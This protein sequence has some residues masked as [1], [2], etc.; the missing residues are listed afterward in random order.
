MAPRGVIAN[1]RRARARLLPGALLVLV[2]AGT[3]GYA[4]L[5]AGRPAA[6]AATPIQHVVF[7]VQENR[8]FDSYFGTFPGAD[9]ISMDSS[10]HPTV[11]VPDPQAGTCAYPFHDSADLNGGGP[12]DN[13]DAVRDIDAGKMDGFVAVKES[14]NTPRNDVMGYHDQRE[15]PV[16]WSYAKQFSLQDHMFGP[17]RAWSQSEH[18][19]LVSGWSAVCSNPSRAASCSTDVQHGDPENASGAPDYA[20]TDITYLLH[21]AGISWKYYVANGTQPDCDDGQVECCP[22]V[23]TA[24]TFE[25]WNP[26]RD[27]ATVHD[28]GELGNI[29][30]VSRFYSAAASGKLPAVSWIVPD[31]R[32]SEHPGSSLSTGQDY[33]SGLINTLMRSP[34]WSSTAVF[35]TWD[36]WGGFYDHVVPPSV[37]SVGYGIRVPGLLLSPWARRGYVDHQVLSFDAYLKFIEHN[38]LGGQRIDPGND[39]RPDPRPDVREGAPI[40]GDLMKEFDFNS[41]PAPVVTGVGS[42]SAKAGDVVTVHGSGLSAATQVLF[43]SRPAAIQTAGSDS[44]LSVRVPNGSG[45]VDVTVTTQAGSSTPVPLD[46]F[47]YAP[48]PVVRRVDP[49]TATP[50]TQ[51]SITG[52]GFS[53]TS[54]VSFG[55]AGATFSV[56]S[57]TTISALVPDPPRN[58]SL[59]DVTVTTPAGVSPTSGRDRFTYPIQGVTGLS[60]SSGP[61]DACTA[62]TVRGYGFTGATAVRFGGVQA[63]TTIPISDTAIEAVSPPGAG[64][65]DVTVVTPRGA[66]PATPQDQYTYTPQRPHVVVVKPTGG[67]TAGG[68]AVQINGSGF[69]G[70]TAVY[71]GSAPAAQFQVT[72]NGSIAAV[73]PPGSG[74]VDVTVTGPRGTSLKSGKF[75]YGATVPSLLSIAPTSGSGTGGTK[76]T[77]AGSGFSNAQRVLFGGSEAQ[78]VKIISDS[79]IQ[80]VAPPGSGTADVQVTN[81]VG[82]SPQVSSDTFTWGGPP[83]VSSVTPSS[84]ASGGGTVVTLTGS[85]FSRASEVLIGGVDATFT[86]LSDKHIS[87]VTPGGSGLVDVTVVTPSGISFGSAF[88]LFRYG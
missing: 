55:G 71:F 48:G 30:D 64:T 63:T 37:D 29:Q 36:D 31:W 5:A 14:T 24:G 73:S 77:I 65:V 50:G 70:A 56:L 44:A 47:S 40:L 66:T 33:V 20:W 17:A 82:E 2:P 32:D 23:Q 26:L 12:H 68:T 81:K 58:A 28:D 78:Q 21:K 11:C 34:D 62:V 69:A 10:G 6:A 13:I 4:L 83:T 74:T 3:A 76:V 57:P 38:W 52:A 41:K 54:N 49:A 9:G 39:G 67:T 22:Q 46:R 88:N 51:V 35:L 80:A 61:P 1:A 85:G 72:S 60:R 25:I 43:G 8:S 59:V 75:T 15:L 16:Y 18:N 87:A 79:E 19:Y 7:I 86:V 45:T 53:T 42:G 27:F 84:G